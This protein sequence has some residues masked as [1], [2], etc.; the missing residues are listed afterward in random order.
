MVPDRFEN[1]FNLGV[2]YHKMGNFQKA[3]QAYQQADAL[4][5]RV[6]AGVPESGRGAAGT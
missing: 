2:A 1:W 5:S 6:G 3:T 4:E